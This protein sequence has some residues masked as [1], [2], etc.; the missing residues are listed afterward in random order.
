MAGTAHAGNSTRIHW[1][2]AASNTDIHLEVYKNQ[3][4]TAFQYNALF[5]HLSTQRTTVPNSN[6]YRIDRMGTSTVKSRTSGVALEDQRVAND[7]LN[8]IVEVV[9]YIRNPIDYQDDWTA[10]DRLTEIGQNN[11][12]EFASV[13]DEA[14]IIQLQKAR[15]WKAPAHL[16][17]A[18]N[19]GIEVAVNLAATATTQAQLEA[20]AIALEQAHKKAV[21][22]LI[23][24]KVPLSGMVT[25]VTPAVFSELTHHPKLLNADFASNNGDFADRRVAR[26]NGINIVECVEFPT[27]V[28]TS[29]AGGHHQL[30]TAANSFGFD[31]TANDL[32]GEMIVFDKTKTLV[33]VEAKP[34]TSTFWDD[35]L[36]FSNVLDCYAMYT[37][38]VRR[39]DTAAVV[40]V[41]RA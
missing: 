25:L 11:G 36:N 30:S 22:T 32:K 9:L 4:D 15:D 2:G 40:T 27:Q 34:F 39:P 29:L 37:V 31:A 8:I 18:F 17:P 41:T 13:F 38:G 35:K 26:V 33:T 28:G 24:R 20:N 10:P 21:E 14:H 16:K 23:T 19:D 5:T 7:K 3:V 1:G 6:N 12:S